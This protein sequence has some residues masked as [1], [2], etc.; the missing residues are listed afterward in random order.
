MPMELWPLIF[1][2]TMVLCNTATTQTHFSSVSNTGN[3]AT[4]GI[5]VSIN[6]TVDGNAF[7]VNDE[8]AVFADGRLMPDSFCVGITRWTKQSTAITVWGDNEQT[9]ALDG[10]RAGTKFH[11][12]VWKSST[13][14]EYT[15]AIVTYARGDSLYRANNVYILA[16]FTIGSIQGNPTFIVEPGRSN[17]PMYFVLHQNFPNPFNPET[18]IG[19][20]L[21]INCYVSLRIFNLLGGEVIT[22]VHEVKE[23]GE[24]LVQWNATGLSSGMYFYRIDAMS[25]DKSN[26]LFSNTRKLSLIR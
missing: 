11:F 7:E 12:H 16:S 25:L 4:I 21:S 10:I 3:N 26:T 15:A 22:L 20:Q 1:I 23:P 5:P 17:R 13:N 14:K 8:I 2:L 19:Y 6:P 9:S 24:H 18:V